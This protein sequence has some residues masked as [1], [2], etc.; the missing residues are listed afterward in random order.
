MKTKIIFLISGLFLIHSYNSTANPIIVEYP[1]VFISELYFDS[2]NNWTLEL[3]M[4][5]HE[6]FPQPGSIDSVVI[7]TNSGRAHL[8]DF[9]SE[10]YTIFLI[11]AENLSSPLVINSSQDSVRILT[12][13]NESTGYTWF[14]EYLEHNLVFGY[15]SSEIPVL[16]PG[17]SIC[18]WEVEYG[19]PVCFYKDNSPTPGFPNDT[20]G[21]TATLRGTFYDYLDQV[22]SQ[23]MYQCDFSISNNVTSYYFELYETSFFVSLDVFDFAN[24]GNYSTH[25]LAGNRTVNIIDNFYENNCPYGYPSLRS[26]TCESFQFNL[27]PGQTMDQSIHL[28]DQTYIVGV[29]KLP[30]FSEDNFT[31][32][33]APNP[34]SSFVD[35]FL[36]SS[37]TIADAEIQLFDTGGHMIKT[38]EVE[39]GVPSWTG[40]VSREELGKPGIY[41]YSVIEKG[42]RIKSGQIICQ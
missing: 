22:I 2:G 31:V 3:E 24:S 42:K 25:V 1:Q 23:P 10:N 36:S 28:T 27:E 21:A 17:Q 38:I 11:A 4:F 37:G 29:D 35:F 34:F 15:P 14:G 16:F 7:I 40:R 19:Y 12:Y 18:T 9:P 20:T 8:L 5:R 6:M 41:L 32:V 26:L 33:C 13:L 39:S 30:P